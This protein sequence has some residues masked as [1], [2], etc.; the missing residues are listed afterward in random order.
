MLHL[1]L[2]WHVD[3]RLWR[4]VKVINI[5]IL[6]LLLLLLT[7]ALSCDLLARVALQELGL[8]ASGRVIGQH[9]HSSLLCELIELRLVNDLCTL[10]LGESRFLD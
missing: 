5:F 1:N 7:T 6:L 10:V 9:L 4:L 8:V 2:L 3:D